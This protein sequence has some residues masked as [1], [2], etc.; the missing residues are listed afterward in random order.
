MPPCVADPSTVEGKRA[1]NALQL[2]SLRKSIPE[3]AFKKSALKASWYMLFDYTMWFGAIFAIY[4]A[5]NSQTWS[6]LPFWQQALATL[7]FWN[8]AGFFMWCV[9]IIGH[10]CGHST[11]SESELL[12]DI[13]GHITH[14]SILVPYYPW[15]VC[16]V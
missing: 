9:F 10:D 2:N 13:V 5:K 4:S 6:M 14:G 7:V 15:Q 8:I 11:F 16:I 1:V 12:N 3:K